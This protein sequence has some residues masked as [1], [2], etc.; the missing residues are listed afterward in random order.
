MLKIELGFQKLIYTT[1]DWP[2]F[3]G[4]LTAPGYV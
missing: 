2:S 4:D 1:D 3:A